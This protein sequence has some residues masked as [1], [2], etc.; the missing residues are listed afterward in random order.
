MEGLIPEWDEQDALLISWP[1]K[2]SDWAYILEEV[3]STYRTIAEKV[4]AYQHLVILAPQGKSAEIRSFFKED[5]QDRLFV[6]EVETNDTWARDYAPLCSYFQGNKIATDY[7]FNGWGQKYPSNYDNLVSRKLVEMG[8]FLEDVA[9]SNRQDFVFEG[10][11]IESNGKGVLLTTQH[12]LLEENRNSTLSL[13][14]LEEDLCFELRGEH[15]LILRNGAIEGDDTDG[16]IDTLAR[17]ISPDRI[18]YVAP[19]DESS[20]NYLYLKRME[21]ELKELARQEGYTLLPLPDAGSFYDEDG[22]PMPATY[23]NFVFVNGGLLV[24][25]YGKETDREALDVLQK[26]LPERKVEGVNCYQLIRQH[27]SL[28]CATMQ[29]PRGFVNLK[30]LKK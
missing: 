2:N 8:F 21:E 15:L 9:W 24:P 27:G 4:L 17:F 11:A 14:E 6:L 25:I 26:A 16:H 28:H 23:A 22:A 30:A 12:C 29:F 18:T 3:E 5:L 13:E 1:H 20:F 7:R 19:T 10:G